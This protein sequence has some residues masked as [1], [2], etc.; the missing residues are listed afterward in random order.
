MSGTRIPPSILAFNLYI[1]LTDTRLQAISSGV[2]KH[3]ERLGLIQ[4]NADQWHTFRL[5][6]EIL[7]AKYSDPMQRTP[8]IIQQVQD[9]MDIFRTF[10]NPQLDIMAASLAAT[11][12]D[13]L[14]FNFKIG[15]AEPSQSNTQIE[16]NLVFK[17]EAIGSGDLKFTCRTSHDDHRASKA[18]GSDS[19]QVAHF[20]LETAAQPQ[21]TPPAEQPAAATIPT[22]TTM[23][24]EIFT[25]SIFTMHFGVENIGQRVVVYLRWYN[26]KHPELSSGWTPVT[27]LAIA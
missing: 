20:I 8:A 22:P 9:F 27:V 1:L 6:W 4:A 25:K 16:S 24:N 5:A 3:W 12:D 17:V 10:A 23:M 2:I 18:E 26:T 7:Y 21:T 13:E 14:A 15:R 11:S 19:I